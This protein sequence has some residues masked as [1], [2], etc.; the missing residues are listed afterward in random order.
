MDTQ[1]HMAGEGVPGVRPWSFLLRVC[2]LQLADGGEGEAKL[3]QG[4]GRSPGGLAMGADGVCF[5]PSSRTPAVP[6][7]L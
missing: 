5:L 3:R 4:P 1:G 7:K 6:T 2:P